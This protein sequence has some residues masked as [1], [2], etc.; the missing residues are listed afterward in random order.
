MI[1]KRKLT[2]DDVLEMGELGLLKPDERIELIEGE[3]YT[4]TPPSFKHAAWVDKIMKS[5]ERAYGD[6]AIIRVQSPIALSAHT[7]PEPDIAVLKFQEDFYETSL[8]Q[9]NQVFLVVEVS[10]SSLGYD[11]DIKLPLYAKAAIPEVWIVNLDEG[12]LEVYREPQGERYRHRLLL[13]PGEAIKPLA[14]PDAS[15]IVIL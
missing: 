5:L 11:R 3:L 6:Y 4:M 10:L 14:F 8:P 12:Q 15:G 2:V 13:Q 1:S 7:S 9:P